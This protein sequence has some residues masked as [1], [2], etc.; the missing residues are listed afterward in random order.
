[1]RNSAQEDSTKSAFTLIELLVV[2]AIIAILAAMLLP[3]LA[4]A[5]QKAHAVACKSNLKQWGIEWAIYTGD[6][7]DCF[8]D[9]DPNLTGL[10]RATWIY[11]LRAAYSRKPDL[12]LCPTATRLREQNDTGETPYTGDLNSA[13][14]EWYG[15]PTTATT[16][17]GFLDPTPDNQKGLLLHSYGFNA[18]AYKEKCR[19]FDKAGLWRKM[20]APPRPTE[21]PL[22]GDAMWRGGAPNAGPGIPPQDF[23]GVA[24]HPNGVLPPNYNG[25]WGALDYE[26]AHFAI[27]RHNKGSQLVFFDGS[28]RSVKIRQLWR[29]EWHRGYNFGTADIVRFPAWMPY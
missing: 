25:Q 14:G 23:K 3:A 28:V 8:P 7:D 4:R 20:S 17:A 11:A 18:W 12:P 9:P 10:D 6:N 2:I 22:M 19:Y 24:N 26:F 29:L 15:G 21:T 16:I 27:V 13:G 1:M 5:K